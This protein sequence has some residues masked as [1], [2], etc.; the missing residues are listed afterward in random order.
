MHDI[1]KKFG[2]APLKSFPISGILNHKFYL[3]YIKGIKVVKPLDY[4]PYTKKIAQ[5]TL[6]EN[7]GWRAYPQK[8]F[9]S[10]FTKFFEGY[11][12]PARYGYD[13]RRVQFSS[14]IVTN[15]M[16]REEAMEKLEQPALDKDAIKA[17]KE[18]I[19]SKLR[20]T[21]EE[22]DSYLELPHKTYKD[23]KNQELLFNFGSKFLQ[24]LGIEKN[25]KR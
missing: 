22:I 15:Q 3:R 4:I 8:H 1:H 12:L 7:Y 9:E 16:T 14:L 21:A 17:D 20:V 18:Y 5:D 24:L 23:Y 6:A 10:R 11:W 25:A 2:T 13:T 19:A